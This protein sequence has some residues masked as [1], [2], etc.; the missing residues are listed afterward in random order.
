VLH[1][2]VGGA[3]DGAYPNS[4][5]LPQSGA[6]VGSTI[7]GGTGTCNNGF[8]V[9]CGTV[10]KVT[11]GGETVLHSFNGADGTYPSVLIPAGKSGF[12]GITGQG[13]SS[14]NG[15]VFHMSSTGA[16]TRLYSFIGGSDGAFPGG[17]VE[18]SSGNLF[19]STYSGGTSGDGTIFELSPNRQGGWTETV[20]YSFTGADGSGPQRG[21][22]L[23]QQNRILY[24]STSEGG[25]L[26]C[27]APYG[28]GT[29]FAL[30]Y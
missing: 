13:G 29:V 19:G 24:G 7:Y 27:Y 8:A 5:L 20:L 4:L 28:C 12:Y 3:N 25:D 1:S 14:G 23:D 21:I 6:L 9:G 10:Y 30:S 15:T 16:V 11:K 26:S 18:D 2:F 17:L 22:A